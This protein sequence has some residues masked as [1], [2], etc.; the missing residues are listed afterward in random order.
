MASDVCLTFVNRVSAAAKV[1]YRPVEA[2]WRYSFLE[3]VC[4]VSGGVKHGQSSRIE[5]GKGEQA[6]TLELPL[7]LS[8]L[9]FHLPSFLGVLVRI[10]SIA[11]PLIIQNLVVQRLCRIYLCQSATTAAAAAATTTTT[12]FLSS[13]RSL[14]S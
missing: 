3:S 11:V 10:V 7:Q 12:T 9:F 1:S 14:S 8:I 6:S 5:R 4:G 2:G 13:F